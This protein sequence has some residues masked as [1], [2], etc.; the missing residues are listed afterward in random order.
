MVASIPAKGTLPGDPDGLGRLG[1]A[2]MAGGA[3]VSLGGFVARDSKSGEV[4]TRPDQLGGRESALGGDAASAAVQALWVYDRLGKT[5][6]PRERSLKDLAKVEIYVTPDARIES[7]NAVHNLVFP[8][9]VPAFSLV[10]V[11]AIDPDPRVQV[12]IGGFA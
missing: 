1:S 8:A 7:L 11:N 6:K 3:L 9:G 2:G 10:P 4:I 12:K 5:L